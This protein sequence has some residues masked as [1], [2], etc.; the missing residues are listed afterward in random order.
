VAIVKNEVGHFAFWA[1]SPPFKD[2]PY[3]LD[4][5][6]GGSLPEL[7]S[8]FDSRSGLIMCF[9]RLFRLG[10]LRVVDFLD[11]GF[12][13]DEGLGRAV[14]IQAVLQKGLDGDSR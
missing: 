5:R 12:R 13:H 11:C 14:R 7:W 4:A 3:S 1:L 6:H 10:L 9:V 2:V 8:D